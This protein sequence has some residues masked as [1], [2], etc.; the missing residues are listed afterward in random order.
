MKEDREEALSSLFLAGE[1]GKALSRSQRDPQ[2]H[3]MKT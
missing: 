3:T 2:K 1:P